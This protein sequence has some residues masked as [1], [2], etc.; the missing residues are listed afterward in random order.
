MEDRVNCIDWFCS[1]M[2]FNKSMN[3]KSVNKDESVDNLVVSLD[4]IQRIHAHV[5]EMIRFGEAKNG[6]LLTVNFLIL[7][8]MFSGIIPRQTLLLTIINYASIGCLI[9]SIIVLFISFVPKL[10]KQKEF[11]PVF[12]GTITTICKDEFIDRMKKIQFDE[13]RKFYCEQIHINSQIA[14]Y[15]FFCFTI[16]VTLSIISFLG[17]ILILFIK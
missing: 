12:F 2:L 9:S 15:K 17:S 3:D 1:K 14:K 7:Y 11:N 8:S 16:A 5:N 6:A 13:L 4:H 10:N